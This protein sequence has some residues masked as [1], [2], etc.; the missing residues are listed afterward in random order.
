MLDLRGGCGDGD[1]RHS[2]SHGRRRGTASPYCPAPLPQVAR[3]RCSSTR[4]IVSRTSHCLVCRPKAP[5]INQYSMPSQGGRSRRSDLLERW[6]LLHVACHADGRC[7]SW[8][9]LSPPRR[10]N[11][12]SISLRLFGPMS[13]SCAKRSSSCIIDNVPNGAG[14]YRLA[15]DQSDTLNHIAEGV[16]CPDHR[17]I[18]LYYDCDSKGR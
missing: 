6:V 18:G 14:T 7:G 17:I 2:S 10:S 16:S 5:A 3:H 15:A 12:S 1:P 11:Q 9:L 4:K 13:C 8:T